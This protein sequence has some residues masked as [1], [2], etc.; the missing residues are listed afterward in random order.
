MAV[1]K[2]RA[3][4]RKSDMNRAICSRNYSFSIRVLGVA[5]K[6]KSNKKRLSIE[7]QKEP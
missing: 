6:K 7:Q 5:L 3:I 1:E 4:A 2:Y